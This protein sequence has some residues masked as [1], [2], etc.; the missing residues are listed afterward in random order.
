MG[1]LKF[2]VE[3]VTVGFLES[4][5]FEPATVWGGNTADV[6]GEFFGAE[7]LLSFGEGWSGT[8]VDV[9]AIEDELVVLRVVGD[10]ILGLFDEAKKGRVNYFKVLTLLLCP[11]SGDLVDVGGLN[12]NVETIRL[13]DCRVTVEFSPF[14]VKQNSG[15]FNKLWSLH[16]VGVLILA[17][18]WKACGF[19]VE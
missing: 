14:G 12:W 13:N 17:F 2:T 16:V 9:H 4:G 18:S 1:V 8:E 10:E 7:K 11:L 19:G 5:P 3:E 6:G 15:Y